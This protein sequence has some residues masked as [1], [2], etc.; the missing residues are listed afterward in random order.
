MAQTL[1]PFHV[2][3]Q[4]RDIFEARQF[5]GELLGLP[6]GR[7]ADTWIDFDMFGH[8]FV[9][10]LN[11]SLGAQGQ[12]GRIENPVDDHGVPVPH[13]GV[14]LDVE[15]W[16][17]FADHLRGLDIDFVIEPY[18][19]FAGEVGEQCTMFLLDPSGNALEFKAFA[20]I[21]QQLFKKG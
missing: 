11:A 9:V 15:R 10:H 18:V 2:A 4:V 6:E 7:S 5:Y 13:C 20:D 8:Q 14:V 19:R 16:H 3:L 1:T 21:E 17:R 12:V